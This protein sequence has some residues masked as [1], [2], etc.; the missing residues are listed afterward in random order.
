[1]T[2][3]GNKHLWHQLPLSSDVMTIILAPTDYVR[4]TS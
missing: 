2:M 4:E 1:M 3:P